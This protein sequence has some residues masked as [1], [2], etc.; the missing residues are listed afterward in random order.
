MCALVVTCVS[1]R[2]CVTISWESYN[3][4]F[5]QKILE[6]SGDTTHLHCETH[7]CSALLLYCCS[8]QVAHCYSAW[9]AYCYSVHAAHCYSVMVANCCSICVAPC[10]S[11]WVAH[12]HSA[13][14]AH[15]YFAMVASCM[16][17]TL[18]LSHLHYHRASP[19]HRVYGT[20]VAV[21]TSAENHDI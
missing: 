8:A 18:L 10:Y 2:Y 16:G 14:V 1:V 20:L 3:I 5:V 9:V 17:G 4:G 11:A 6:L 15:C 7:C 13:Q 19:R 12:C 21:P